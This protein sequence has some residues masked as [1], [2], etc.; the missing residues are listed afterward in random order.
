MKR[1]QS[2]GG[3]PPPHKRTPTPMAGDHPY[4]KIDRLKIAPAVA[5]ES[6]KPYKNHMEDPIGETYSPT[7]QRSNKSKNYSIISPLYR[8]NRA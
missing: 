4:Y 5:R 8:G 1:R 2:A 3:T 7:I 6:Q